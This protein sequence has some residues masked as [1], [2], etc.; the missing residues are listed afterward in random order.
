VIAALCVKPSPR[1]ER[2]AM[3]YHLEKQ[4]RLNDKTEH[5]SLYSWCLEEIDSEGEKAGK[6]FIPWA[7]SFHFTAS[8]LR[9]NQ[10]FGFGELSLFGNDEKEQEEN[11]EQ[12]FEDS[13]VITAILHAGICTDGKR[14]EDDTRF[15]MFG[16]DRAI[17]NFSLRIYKVENEEKERCQIWGGVSYTSEIDFRNETSPDSIE[18]H[19]ALSE[20]RFNKLAELISTNR[21]DSARIGLSRVSGF[22]SEWSPSISTRMV[23]VLTSGSE[24]EIIKSDGCDIN[25]PR[26]GNIGKFDL[27]LITRCKLNPKQDFTALNISKAFDDDDFYEEER[28]VKEAEDLTQLALARIVQN[29]VEIIKLKTPLWIIT[30]LVGAKILSSWF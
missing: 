27:T 6:D 17:T 8:E 7:W 20:A 1:E 12:N 23:K 18:I 29:Q 28:E 5:K 24:H 30:F 19:L 25:P 11:K 9:L 13:E 16:T 26:L 15:S 14:L 4:I 10:G 22:Y 3:D 21:I 2:D